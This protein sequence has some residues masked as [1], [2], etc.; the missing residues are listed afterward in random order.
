MHIIKLRSWKLPWQYNDT[1]A[2]AS[3]Y[4]YPMIRYNTPKDV[5]VIAYHPLPEIFHVSTWD[6]H[7]SNALVEQTR[8]IP[9]VCHVEAL[10]S[11]LTR[12]TVLSTSLQR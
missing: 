1:I 2:H 8:S 12:K 5:N 9:A 11:A 4:N 7:A 6:K 10:C 3:R